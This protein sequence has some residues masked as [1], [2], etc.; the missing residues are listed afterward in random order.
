MPADTPDRLIA[1]AR[2]RHEQTL[3]RAR[4]ALRQLEATGEPVTYAKVAA[5]AKVSRAWLYS[6]PDVRAAVE[7]LRDINNRSTGVAVP[8]RQR[9]SEASL[10]RRLEAAHRRSQ[11]LTRQVAELREQLA[12]AHGALRDSRVGRTTH[13]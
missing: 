8:T 9:T 2:R 5:T 4:T 13:T 6:Q 7:R 3:A 10:V 12:A 1:A 11:E